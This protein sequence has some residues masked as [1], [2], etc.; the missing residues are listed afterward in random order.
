MSCPIFRWEGPQG[1][2]YSFFNLINTPWRAEAIDP[3]V[4]NYM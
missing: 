1:F 3:C 4:Y 2:I